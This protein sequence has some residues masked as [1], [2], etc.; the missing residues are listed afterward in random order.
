MWKPERASAYT[1]FLLLFD[2]VRLTH[3]VN[4]TNLYARLHPFCRPNYQWFD[5]NADEIRSLLGILIATGCVSLPNIAD[6]WEINTIFSQ[7]GI[8]KGMSQ[9]HF[10]QLCGWLHFNENSMVFTHGTPGYDQLQKIRLVLDAICG[11][12]KH[13]ITLDKIF[14]LM[15]LW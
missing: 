12:S 1:Y 2:D 13:Y 9:N 15:K 4:Q 8:V 11:K 5:N 7:S 3:I 10:E 14:Q 6:Y